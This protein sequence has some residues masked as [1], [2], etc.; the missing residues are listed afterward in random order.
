MERHCKKSI[1]EWNIWTHIW[2]N[3]QYNGEGKVQELSSQGNSQR[4]IAKILKVGIGTVNRDVQYLKQQAKEN[5]RR[6]IDE[7]LPEEYENVLLE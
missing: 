1:G 5:I 2:N 4:D 6:Y 7:R 3:N